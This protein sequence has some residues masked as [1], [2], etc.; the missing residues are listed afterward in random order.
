MTSR[1]LASATVELV[2][3]L[4]ALAA[5]GTE[6]V[7]VPFDLDGVPMVA[8]FAIKGEYVSVGVG[9]KSISAPITALHL[10]CML[11]WFNATKDFTFSDMDP[12]KY[13]T[14]KQ[15][16]RWPTVRTQ[17]LEDFGMTRL[18]IIVDLMDVVVDKVWVLRAATEETPPPPPS[19]SE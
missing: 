3:P 17:V 4:A 16:P 19:S 10:R 11:P 13:N 15:V 1:A 6:A 12:G 8:A 7:M 14:S 9:P 5:A 2:D 18:P